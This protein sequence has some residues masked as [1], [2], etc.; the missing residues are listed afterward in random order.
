MYGAPVVVVLDEFGKNLEYMAQHNGLG[1]VYI[2][3]TLAESP[4][5]YL[6]VCLHQ[7]FEEYSSEFSGKQLQEWGKI[8]GRFEDIS[9]VEPQQQMIRFIAYTL[10]KANKVSPFAEKLQAW[11]N[12]YSEQFSA[13]SLPGPLTLNRKTIEDCYPLH[14]LVVYVLPELCARLFYQIAHQDIY[15]NRS[16]Y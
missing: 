11:T 14:P 15:Y 3:Q 9:F 13:L 1:D 2:L 4:N 7:A 12:F 10:K 8:Q 16:A 5:I 6:W